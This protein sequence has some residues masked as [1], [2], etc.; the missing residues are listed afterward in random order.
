MLEIK[1]V[2]NQ[3]ELSKLKQD[4]FA[5]STAPLDGMWHFGFAPM[6]AHFGFYE[7]EAL[8]GYCCIN[9]EGYMLQFY[10]AP[11]A[12]SDAKELFTLIAEQNSAVIGEVKGAFVSTAEPQYLSLCFD[13]SSAFTVNALMY[14]QVQRGT[15]SNQSALK[16]TLAQPE[17]LDQF[18][19]FAA[20]NIGAPEQWLSGYF[21]NL[22][23]RN[24]LFGYWLEGELLATGE[25]RLFDEYQTDYADLG[26]IV[27]Q[28]QRGKGIAT[29]VLS[30]LVTLANERGLSPMCST[31]R[32]NTGA[33][34]AIKRAGLTPLNRIIQ[35]EFDQQ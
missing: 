30:S 11:N 35:I 7:H 23:K 31:E 1:P 9:G 6:A 29:Q 34:K 10:L 21:G 12:N 16:L 27:A 20:S 18:V 25:C 14:Q 26:M 22:I 32:V 13:N 17:Q 28:S 19:E 2:E 24:E 3:Q 4:Y 15:M 33:Q 8:V 5:Q